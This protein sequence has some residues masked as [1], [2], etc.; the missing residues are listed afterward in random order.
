MLFHSTHCPGTTR[1]SDKTQRVGNVS[2]G[3]D[4]KHSSEGIAPQLLSS[5]MLST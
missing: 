1:P 2:G 3:L 5:T 4:V